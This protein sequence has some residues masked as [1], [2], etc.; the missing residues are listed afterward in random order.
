M[1]AKQTHTQSQYNEDNNESVGKGLLFSQR[2][3]STK[4]GLRIV[5]QY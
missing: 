3:G 5:S 1:T 4:Q 2:V